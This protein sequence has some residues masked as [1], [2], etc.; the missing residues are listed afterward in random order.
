MRTKPINLRP[1]P[2]RRVAGVAAPRATFAAPRLR[3][4]ILAQP[5]PSAAAPL[6]HRRQPLIAP[7]WDERT[8]QMTRLV[9]APR[10]GYH[11]TCRQ[12]VVR[13]DLGAQR[14]E[15]T[16]IAEQEHCR[17][18]LAVAPAAHV[19]STLLAD[20]DIA[21]VTW[22]RG[23][24]VVP[25]DIDLDAASMRARCGST[26]PSRIA[27]MHVLWKSASRRC[28]VVRSHRDGASTGHRLHS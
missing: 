25:A 18:A 10:H 4:T 11:V 12:F 28:S 22:D 2:D 16:C 19:G 20:D 9:R 7:E 17:D 5:G 27:Y 13:S 15:E 24:T 21:R 1:T 26:A 14:I 6:T 3:P 23:L 8:F